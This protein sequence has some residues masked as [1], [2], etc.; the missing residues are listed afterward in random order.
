MWDL[1]L[2]FLLAPTL[3]LT[4]LYPEFFSGHMV[5]KNVEVDLSEQ[6]FHLP[7]NLVFGPQNNT[8]ADM[9]ISLPSY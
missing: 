9:F 6:D 1:R 4:F 2:P 7:L 3:F 5:L 8:F